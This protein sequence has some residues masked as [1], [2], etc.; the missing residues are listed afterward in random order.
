MSIIQPAEDD[1]KLTPIQR[2][3]KSL[4][5]KSCLEEMGYSSV[6]DI[7]RQTKN[8]FIKQN[9]QRLGA[10]VEPVYDLAIGQAQ[11]IRRLFRKNQLT[12][13]IQN[14][15]PQT[16]SGQSA[17]G[18]ARGSIQGLKQDGPTWQN[19]FAESW[20]VYCQANSPEAYNSPASYLSWLYNQALT[21]ELEITSNGNEVIKLSERRPDLASMMIDNDAINQ[22]IP[23]LE[24][25]NQIMEETLSNSID[26]CGTVDE[27]LADTRYPT[28]LPY[29]F[30]H[31]QAML[32]LQNAQISLED[33][34]SQTDITWPYFLTKTLANDRAEQALAL[35]SRLAPL[36]QQILI[37]PDNCE[38]SGDFT[39]F[40]TNNMAVATADYTP[41]E[42]LDIFTYQLG[43][44]VPQV[45]QLMAGTAG[46]TSV[47]LSPNA[48][49][50][51]TSS[52]VTSADY[53]AAFI[54]QNTAAAVNLSV[55]VPVSILD[56]GINAD[57]KSFVVSSNTDMPE[58]TPALSPA[59]FGYG[60][61]L[62]NTANSF[63]YLIGN[64]DISLSA[65]VDFSAAFW[66]KVSGHEFNHDIPVLSN[67]NNDAYMPGFSI[68]LAAD[69]VLYLNVSDDSVGKDISNDDGLVSSNGLLDDGS[70]ANFTNNVWYFVCLS[71]DS[72]D[73]KAMIYYAPKSGLVKTITVDCSTLTGNIQ[74]ATGYQWTFNNTGDF[75]YYDD[76]SEADGKT[77]LTIDELALYWE[78]PLSAQ[79]VQT[80]VDA[81]Q[82]TDQVILASPM[83]IYHYYSFYSEM[84]LGVLQ[85]LN[86]SRMDR[87]NRMVRLQRWLNL[88][89]EQV[90]LLL[91]ACI[92]AQGSNNT[93]YTLN[94]HI[95]RV[96]GVFR[97]W[98]QKYNLSAYEFAAVLHQ[99]SPYAITPAVPFLDQIFN[100][101]SLFEKPFAL[102][103]S[104]VDYTQATGD[105]A[106]T[107][108]Q[109]CAGLGLTQA[110]FRVLADNV[111]ALQPGDSGG[112]SLTL[113]LDTVSA[114]Y[115]LAMLPRWL[116]LSFAEGSALFSL[117]QDNQ[118]VWASLAGEPQL[119]VLNSSD[120]PEAS[121]ILDVLMALD[122]AADWSKTHGLS[123]VDNYLALQDA[124]KALIATAETLNFI[125][126][127]NQQ[128]PATLVTEQ[129]FISVAFPDGAIT[130]SAH[131]WLDVLDDLIDSDG[132]ILLAATDEE[133][134]YCAVAADIADIPF[135]SSVDTDQVTETLSSIIYQAK[136]TQSGIADSALAQL[137][138]T[139]QS[140]SAFLLQWAED[141]EYGLLSASLALAGVT[142]TDAI[143]EAYLQTL[144]TLGRYATVANQFQLTPAALNAF[145][146]HPD[147]FGVDST[148]LTLRLLYLF[149]RYVDWLILARK[150]N[151]VL[152]YL[153]WVNSAGSTATAATAATV[154]ADLLQWEESEVELAAAQINSDGTALTLSEVDYVMRQQTLAAKT[155][156]S[157]TPLLEVGELML[158]ST[159]AQWQEAGES[160]VAAQTVQ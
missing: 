25:V 70:T 54:N 60:L 152:T 127:I 85:N 105:N 14:A 37:E 148:K 123:W 29:H 108:K 65:T 61:T 151:A 88:P 8:T 71:W 142:D 136:L 144:Y 67:N 68:I 102:T 84:T 24:L 80:I 46:G 129:S 48:P 51:E 95:L 7:V 128:L 15:L 38:A 3:E 11:H 58:C 12:S 13:R 131:G 115:R 42:S 79:E 155:A 4:E 149:S 134:I 100:S 158:D 27:T 26:S 34:V 93:D 22:V 82:P 30:P 66:I 113:D 143:P 126:G 146:A 35:A 118:G 75:S 20:T 86:D 114:L 109:L 92:A 5:L 111:A 106:R 156:L 69:N 116:G 139:L 49:M 9:N 62:Y 23:A 47:T 133:T 74:H 145:L 32:S 101:P 63:G 33:I 157:V 154:L 96:L 2:I 141:S 90:D 110:Q 97:H 81:H 135:D 138:K 122:S 45:E 59:L 40:Y 104:T 21:F 72:V 78:D 10:R 87:I 130:S 83:I 52:G 43:L 103:G 159:Y 107:V 28:L 1:R 50:L 64:A 112:Q 56:T 94:N 39:D 120:Q 124:P 119:A 147:W 76:L 16:L 18:T 17:V 125:N 57:N 89:Y 41:F 73:K 19:Q 98:Q 121:D 117:L 160:L 31:D 53:G 150:E 140:L 77:V 153:N 44:S 36:Q 99:I 6:F 137:F 55:K 91:S 132:L